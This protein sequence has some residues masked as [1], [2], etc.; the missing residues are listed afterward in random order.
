MRVESRFHLTQFRVE[1]FAEE[2]RAVLRA[3]PFPVLP[4]QQ[5]AVFGG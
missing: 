1:L 5:T 2:C 4:P 3:E